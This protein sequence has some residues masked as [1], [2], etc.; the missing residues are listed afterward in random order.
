MVNYY[1]KMQRVTPT[2]EEDDEKE[3]PLRF[4]R[5]YPHLEHINVPLEAFKFAYEERKKYYKSTLHAL[6]HED[7]PYISTGYRRM[8]IN[9]LKRCLWSAFTIHNDTGN[10]WTHAIAGI[11]FLYMIRWVIEEPRVGSDRAIFIMY[12]VCASI[13][14][15]ASAAYHVYRPH[16]EHAYHF[17]LSCDLRG[18]L[19]LVCGTNGLIQALGLKYFFFWKMVWLTLT[20]SL[21]VALY[22]WVPHMVR[23]RL[24]KRRTIYFA[25]YA[26]MGLIAW[27]Q[28]RFL[29]HYHRDKVPSFPALES[30]EDHHHVNWAI[31][32]ALGVCYGTQ[33][34]GL[35][36]RGLKIP[37]RFFP[38]VFDIIGSSH[39]IFHVIVALG[40]YLNFVNIYNL[41]LQG[42][43]PDMPNE[44]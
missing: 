22:N 33:A 28:H 14:M 23:N 37:E 2:T 19:I 10:I 27:Y 15:L 39:Q 29:L 34:F 7:M 18:I 24:T 32:Q 40:A 16:S 36:F 38:R 9:S 4:F 31:L 5:P 42:A 8:P 6:M 44:T 3:I 43:F 13:T 1:K 17:C 30:F 11:I 41:R 25:S 12:L 21:F 20:L 26:L 35:L